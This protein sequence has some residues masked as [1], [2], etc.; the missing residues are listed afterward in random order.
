[1]LMTRKPLIRGIRV[2]QSLIQTNWLDRS[3]LRSWSWLKRVCRRLVRMD[4]R[5]AKKV[6]LKNETLASCSDEELVQYRQSLQA[7][8]KTAAVNRSILIDSFAL[9]REVSGRTLGMRHHSTQIRASLCLLRGEVSEMATGEGKTLAATLACAT[10]ALAGIPVHLVT[11]NDYLAERDAEEMQPLY[12][13]LGLSLGIVIHG[14]EQPDRRQAYDADITY[15]SNKE[16][17]F[18]FLKDRIA[19]DA[20]ATADPAMQL[21]LLQNEGLESRIMQRGLHFAI[22]DEADSVFI[23]EARTPLIISGE[24]KFGTL[25]EQLITQAMNMAKGLCEGKDFKLSEH[26]GIQLTSQGEKH[27]EQICTELGGLWQGREYRQALVTQ[28][29]SAWHR[30]KRNRDYIVNEEGEVQIVDVYTGRVTPG[31]SWGQG[32]HQ[33]IEYKEELELTRPRETEAEISYQNFF[34]KYANLAGMTGT[35]IEVRKE[36][37]SVFKVNCTSIPQLR[38]N[39]RRRTTV[40]VLAKLETKY[41]WV[42]AQ[43]AALHQKGQPVLVGTATVKASEEIA[44]VLNRQGL[45]FQLLN[46]RQDKQEAEIVARAGE[47][48]AITIATGMAGRG[49][50][51]KLSEEARKAGGLHVIITELQD[52]SRIDRQFVG[53]SARQGDPG[54]FSLILSLEDSLLIRMSKPATRKLL[55]SVVAVPVWRNRLGHGLLRVCQLRLEHL[56]HSQRLQLIESDIKRQRMLSFAGKSEYSI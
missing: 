2:E 10:A 47:A 17:V 49:T 52:A 1:M 34:R 33:M 20:G 55:T 23:D 12:E 7:R 56:H 54:E 29:L 46:A 21:G 24:E 11:V 16:L 14:M 6:I 44:E 15:C 50:D 35:G 22:V 51:I 32:L 27:L 31:R 13:A 19:L 3:L 37:L 9:I 36:L 41:T 26:S 42:A 30:Y 28:A 45:N 48:G 53:R 38:K 40:K 4:Q 18:D 39:R 25:E 5:F 8:L 43:V